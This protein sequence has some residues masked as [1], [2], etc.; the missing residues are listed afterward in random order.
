[1]KKIL[2]T[3]LILSILYLPSYSAQQAEEMFDEV[4]NIQEHFFQSSITSTPTVKDES[5]TY[6]KEVPEKYTDHMPFF[7]ETRLRIQQGLKKH[8]ALLEEKRAEKEE[9]RKIKAEEKVQQKL[10]KEFSDDSDIQNVVVKDEILEDKKQVET[11]DT[12]TELVGGVQEHVSE[13][14]VVLDCEDLKYDYETGDI[15]AVGNPK[16]IFPN[17]DV[18]LTAD[19]ITYNKESNIINATK[20]V[21]IKKQGMSV[22][23]DFIRI[24]MNEENIFMD[25]V[26]SSTDTFRIVA[27]NA[28]DVN[29]KVILNEGVAFS[30]R[31]EKLILN[32]PMI[33]PDL[34]QMIVDEKDKVQL[35]SGERAKMKIV[36]SQV[37]VNA[38]KS[39]D[40]FQVKD[41]E[42]YYNN[43]YLLTLP[44]LT[45]YTN[46][47]REYAETNIPEFG[48]RSHMGMYIGPGVVLPAPFGSII[49]VMPMLNYNNKL[50]FGGAA[51]FKSA[52]N[53]T[54]IMYGSAVGDLIVRGRQELDEN[55]YLQ[56]GMNSFMD[57]W[58][59]GYR[60]PKYSAELIYNKTHTFNNF[61]APKKDFT[62]QQRASIGY[63]QD[64]DWNT[65]WENI[66]GSDIGTLRMRYMAQANQVLYKW[67]NKENR[68]YAELSFVGQGSA[69]VYGT[70]DTQFIIRGGPKLHTQYKYWLQDIQY[71]L[72]GYSDNTPVPVYDRYRYGHQ[73]IRIAEALRLHKYVT[74]G[75][76]GQ[77]TL[78]GDSPNGRMFQE[79]AFVL[80]LGPDDIKFNIA[81]DILRESTYCN[82][83]IAIDT[84]NTT[85]EYDKMT[86]KNPELLSKENKE[87]ENIAFS[88]S[89][90]NE[91]IKQNLM[92]A[93]VVDIEDPIKESIQ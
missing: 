35:L 90:E 58:F 88:S 27:K 3:S 16:L 54:E 78:S 60:M 73:S 86:I 75:W 40:R 63:V 5:E 57:E 34:T 4:N 8:D 7:K 39:H 10:K 20:N 37:N 91:K 67:G 68:K 1:M 50:G 49:K 12:K 51:K 59:L 42:F 28:E 14:E 65:R 93:E 70:G 85:V 15:I 30:D 6:L 2:L 87:K 56:Y 52:F 69:S 48:S 61:L 23:G 53:N 18:E 71:F 55:L 45:A 13:N 82:V 77:I 36:A 11:V 21:V 25:N 72:S 44:S 32:T 89:N 29:G 92:Y 74:I 84:K 24:N 41:A 66:H 17:Q 64:S 22:T 9:L 43:K 81:Y 79:N 80:S 31:S 38:T 19:V 46:K 62:Y 26:K 33:G 47:K 76:A 83:A